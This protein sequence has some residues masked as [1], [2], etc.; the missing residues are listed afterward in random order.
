MI[1]FLLGS[2][3]DVATLRLKFP[4]VPNLG[5]PK[6]PFLSIPLRMDPEQPTRKDDDRSWRSNL[7]LS[8]LS[9]PV[10]GSPDNLDLDDV[11]GQWKTSASFTDLLHRL[12]SKR[13]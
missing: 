13:D 9:G 4:L 11:I 7:P 12:S 8:D 6:D 1:H 3:D 10:K 5:G 2:T